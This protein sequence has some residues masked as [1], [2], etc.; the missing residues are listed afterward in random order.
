MAGRHRAFVVLVSLSVSS[1]LRPSEA[2]RVVKKPDHAMHKI[3]GSRDLPIG[4]LYRLSRT[5]R[6][7]SQLLVDRGER[8]GKSS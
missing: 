6:F 1:G 5:F 8:P 7:A 2:V 3:I 4:T